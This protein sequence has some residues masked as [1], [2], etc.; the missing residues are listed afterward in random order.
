MWDVSL[1]TRLRSLG[2]CTFLGLRGSTTERFEQPCAGDDINHRLSQLRWPQRFPRRARAELRHQTH[3]VMQPL[4]KPFPIRTFV[5]YFFMKYS[6]SI[7]LVFLAMG[8]SDA[9]RDNPLDPLSPTYAG[10]AGVAGTVLLKNQGTPIPGAQVRSV[11]DGIAVTTEDNGTYSFPRLT[12]GAQ[13]LVCATDNFVPDTQRVSLMSGT[14]RIVS[15]VLNGAPIVLSTKILTRKIDQYFP[16]PQYYVDVVADVTDPNGITDLDS[17]WFA[18]DTLRFPM[19]YIPSTKLWQTT[20]FKYDLPTGTIQWLVGMPL[21]IVSKDRSGA[22]NIGVDFFITRVI[23]NGATPIYPSSLNSDTTSGTPLLEWTPPAVTFNYSSTLIVSRVDAGTQTI[24]W[25]RS[26]I[27]SF[28]EEYQYPTD[29][30]A[31]ALQ[32]GSYVWTV[33]IVDEF[34]NSCRSKESSFVVR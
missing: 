25:T 10:E 22:V 29:G 21:Q 17:V 6:A 31:A 3:V 19:S 20:V 16:S 30:S 32:T 5:V 18:V 24:V 14:S 11:E 12:S 13:T 8:C 15:F 1:A 9:P 28:F 33:T 27:N 2:D 34:G 23:E 7:L 26:G 4:P